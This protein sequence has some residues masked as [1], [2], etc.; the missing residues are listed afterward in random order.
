L[1]GLLHKG[2]AVWGGGG[3]LSV[4]CLW[5]TDE[6]ESVLISRRCTR[7]TRT[8]H[9]QTDRQANSH[10]HTHRSVRSD[11]WMCKSFVWCLSIR[12]AHFPCLPCA[13]LP[14]SLYGRRRGLIAISEFQ[15]VTVSVALRLPGGSRDAHKK[16]REGGAIDTLTHISGSHAATPPISTF[17]VSHPFVR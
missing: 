10:T 15:H 12:F 9:R 16:E 17:A 6:R 5:L 13:W 2:I 11:V 3:R 1:A 14:L 7:H 4:T 8:A